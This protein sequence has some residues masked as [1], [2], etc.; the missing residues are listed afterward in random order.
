MPEQL[1]G[2]RHRPA[3]RPIPSSTIPQER[4]K[5]AFIEGAKPEPASLKPVAQLR[6]EHAL[7]L[8]ARRRVALRV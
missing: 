7:R 1:D 2:G 4:A 5:S 6:H 3:P 8:D